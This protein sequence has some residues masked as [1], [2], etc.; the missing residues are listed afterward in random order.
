MCHKL[1]VFHVQ[2]FILLTQPHLSCFLIFSVAVCFGVL[3]IVFFRTTEYP[4]LSPNQFYILHSRLQ[5]SVGT[6]WQDKDSWQSSTHWYS[7]SAL[8]KACFFPLFFIRYWKLFYRI[9]ACFFLFCFALVTAIYILCSD[10]MWFT[11]S[12][13]IYYYYYFVF[14]HYTT[15]KKRMLKCGSDKIWNHI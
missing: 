2:I 10:C 14:Q 13:Y 15:K 12:L 5:V 6:I 3:K 4:N 7:V 9:F 8:H 11:I 1:Y